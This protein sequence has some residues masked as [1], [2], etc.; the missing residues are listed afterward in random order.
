MSILKTYI[1]EDSRVIRH[2]LIA[3]LEELAPV[4]VVGT[5]EDQDAAIAWL[6]DPQHE[7]DLVIIDIFLKGGS[8]LGVLERA[9]AMPRALVLVV[10]SN[11]ATAD[12]RRTCIAMGAK[13]VFDKS[14]EIDGLVAFCNGDLA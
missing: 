6:A 11:Y 3:A 5:A 12:M 2:N 1:V 4:E 7:C 14:Q 9:H 8:G 13:R 10:L